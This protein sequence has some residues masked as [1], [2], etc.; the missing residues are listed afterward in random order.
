MVCGCLKF[1]NTCHE[2]ECDENGD[3]DNESNDGNDD[4]EN[5]DDE[6]DDDNDDG[7]DDDDDIFNG[8]N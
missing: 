7:K 1:C 3:F 2:K 8:Y 4:N 5:D 6:I